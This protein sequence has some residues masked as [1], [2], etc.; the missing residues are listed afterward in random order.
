MR[1][2][3]Q[4]LARLSAGCE[5]ATLQSVHEASCVSHMAWRTRHSSRGLLSTGAAQ[6]ARSLFD[7]PDLFRNL[8]S[9]ASEEGQ[10]KLRESSPREK[11]QFGPKEPT[12]DAAKSG[13]GAEGGAS[14]EGA[15]PEAA[16]ESPVSEAM[17][18]MKKRVAELEGR[19]EELMEKAKEDKDAMLRLMADMEN[20]R[21]RTAR[22]IDDTRKFALQKMIQDILTV[23]DNMERALEHVPGEVKTR[24][25]PAEG[26][27]YYAQLCNLYEGI[28]LVNGAVKS[29]LTTNGVVR[30]D[31]M[32]KRF[33]PNTMNALFEIPDATKKDKEVAAVVKVGYILNGRV[34]RPADVGVAT[35]GAEWPAE[36]GDAAQGE[37][38]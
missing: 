25:G 16:G 13:A 14:G 19:T 23:A 22:Q 35:G 3:L 10:G 28:N 9:G 26:V 6:P 5:G 12:E 18:T 17:E 30:V 7:R 15:G 1:R 27:D 34:I 24:E 31:P 8:F 21:A 32:G 37:A 11:E 36:A 4:R 2:A 29:F 38:K 33:D 20:L